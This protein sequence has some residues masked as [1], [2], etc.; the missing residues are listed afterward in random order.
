MFFF[1]KKHGVIAAITWKPAE[2]KDKKQVVQRNY[3][4]NFYHVS[5]VM[6][7]READSPECICFRNFQEIVKPT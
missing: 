7:Q 5:L 6:S 4:L 3:P 1:N 2:R